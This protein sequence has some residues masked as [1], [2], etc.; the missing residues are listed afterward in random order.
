VITIRQI[1][2]GEVRELIAEL[3]A[4]QNSLYPAES[5]HLDSIDDLRRPNVCMIALFCQGLP[6]AIGAIKIFDGYGEIK[7]VYV[8]RNHRSKGYAKAIMQELER[9]LVAHGITTAR[10]E[11]GIKQHEAIS[12]YRRYGYVQRDAFGPYVEDP[13]SLFMEKQLN[14]QTDI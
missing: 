3:D 11:T 8:P 13:L 12:L 2:P 1:D 10:L 9:R 7:R 4:F 6:V 5:N 14:G